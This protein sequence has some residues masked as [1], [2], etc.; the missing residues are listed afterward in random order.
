[1]LI[2][3][4]QI[5]TTQN[6]AVLLSALTP[7]DIAHENWHAL[8]QRC[9]QWICR[10]LQVKT[11]RRHARLIQ[12]K[13]AAYASRQMVF[14][15]ALLPSERIPAFVAWAQ[16][17]L[18]TQ[19]ENFSVRFQPALRGLELA[20]RSVSARGVSIDPP[21]A[22]PGSGPKA[23]RLLGWCNGTHELLADT[24]RTSQASG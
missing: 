16:A 15:L 3:Q 21:C 12:V 14:F 2:E 6:L 22:A 9:F 11:T 23:R 19:S 20:A 1:M 17:H 24:G 13:N 18:D 5:L 8:A 7:G 10:R 4:Q